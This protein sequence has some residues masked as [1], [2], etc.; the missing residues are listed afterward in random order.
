MEVKKTTTIKDATVEKD[1]FNYT[2][3]YQ[4]ENDVLTTVSCSVNT[5]KEVPMPMPYGSAQTGKQLHEVGR[6]MQMNGKT[7]VTLDS[8]EDL[9]LHAMNYADFLKQIN[10]EIP[11]SKKEE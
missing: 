7:T 4:T 9:S 10:A 5:A 11:V 2:L 1:G 6:F 3:K 8:T